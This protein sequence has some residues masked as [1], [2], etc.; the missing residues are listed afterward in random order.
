MPPGEAVEGLAGDIVLH[1]LTLELDAVCAMSNHGLP[2]FESPTTRSMPFHKSVRLQGRTP[3]T[4]PILERFHPAARNA[5]PASFAQSANASCK[6]SPMRLRLV[7]SRSEIHPPSSI[8]ATS[9]H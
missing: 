1:D 8:A 9:R 7:A 6:R 2:S 4:A 3:K 5:S